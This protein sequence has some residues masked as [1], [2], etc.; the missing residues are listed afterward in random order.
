M[1][2]RIAYITITAAV[3]CAAFFIGRNTAQENYIPLNDC[4]PLSDIAICYTGNN[5]YPVFELADIT[6][7]LDDPKNRSYADIMNTIREHYDCVE[8][9]DTGVLVTYSDG[10]GY[11]FEK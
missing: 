1:K 10:T 2:K 9:T 6:C 8:E 7:Q 5:D 4:I 3:T 11:Y